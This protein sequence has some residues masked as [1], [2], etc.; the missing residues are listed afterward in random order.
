MIP[1][2]AVLMLRFV[3]AQRRT[4][5]PRAKRSVAGAIPAESWDPLSTLKP[6]PAAGRTAVG[7]PGSET[8]SSPICDWAQIGA[9][10]SR[11]AATLVKGVLL[12]ISSPAPQDVDDSGGVPRRF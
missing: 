6:V 8:N 4:W 7:A 12:G 3:E 9:G 1:E 5:P 11:S 10:R 2:P